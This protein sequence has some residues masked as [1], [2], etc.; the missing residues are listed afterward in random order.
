M[1]AQ[2]DVADL[3]ALP[4]ARGGRGGD[5]IDCLGLTL[6][7]LERVGIPAPDPWAHVHDAWRKGELDAATGF[8]AGWRRIDIA[9][10]GLDGDVLLFDS[11]GCRA[12]HVAVLFRGH[13]LHAAPEVGVYSRPWTVGH[14]VPSQAWRYQP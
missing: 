1:N 4:F 7:V 11:G 2:P 12:A 8:G 13:V 6:A 5:G 9:E 10:I 3:M 14:D